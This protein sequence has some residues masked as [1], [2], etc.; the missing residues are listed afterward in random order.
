MLN[1]RN[2]NLIFAVAFLLLVLYH[3]FFGLSYY[4][5]LIL[6]LAYSLILIYGSYFIRAGFYIHSICSLDTKEKVIALSFDD[7]PVNHN[8]PEILEILKANNVEAIFFCVG[9]NIQRNGHILKS[10]HEQGHIIGNHSYSHHFWF[11]L[12]SSSKMLTDMQAMD[13]EMKTIF[14]VTPRFF[15]PPYGVT[16]PN[17]KKAIKLGHY[18]PIGW[19]IRSFDTVIRDQDKLLKKLIDSVKPGGIFL[20]HDTSKTTVVILERLIQY[21]HANGYAIRRLDKMLKLD[22]YA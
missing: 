2:T 1:F 17:L 22:P 20:F 7:G 13:M 5:Y 21:L 10:I 3:I 18:I 4:I 9:K 8:T 11:D 16:N 14:G 15:R 6:F 12:F 19:S